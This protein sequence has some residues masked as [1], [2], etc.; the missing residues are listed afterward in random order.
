MTFACS[1]NKINPDFFSRQDPSPPVPRHV[2]PDRGQRR[3]LR[4]GDAQRVLQPPQDPQEVRPQ[5]VHG[6][7][8]GL[9]EG[10]GEEPSHVQG[11]EKNEV[12]IG[13]RIEDLN[14]CHLNGR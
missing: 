13:F 5:G 10:E 1:S 11:K 8:G 3:A 12:V 9:A 14:G 7:Q 4:G 2:P 6:G